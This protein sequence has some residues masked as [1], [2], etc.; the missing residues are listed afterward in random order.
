MSA[1]TP[2]RILVVD[3]EAII[4]ELIATALR[5]EGF[6]VR[7]AADG[8]SAL[9]AV[10]DLAPDLVVLDVMLPDADGFTLQARIRADGQQVPVL[11]LSARD[12]VADRV[13]GLMLGADDY[14]TK[15]FSL[16]E[17]VA[18]IYSILRRTSST[19]SASHRLSFADLE[20]D[21]ET[22]DVR[23]GSRRI[24]LSPTEFQLLRYL[25]LNSRKVLSKS[26]ILDHVWQYDFGGNGRI[27]ETYISNLRKKVDADAPPLIHTLRGVGYSLR[28]PHD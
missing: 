18:R 25:L 24:E 20:L 5:Y 15:P 3:D 9:A 6:D 7:L 10:R 1:E 16:Q 8:A 28:L 14:M 17:L 23:R 12:T 4:A 21:D 11:F 13:R 26:Q 19:N 22:H 2:K 27:V